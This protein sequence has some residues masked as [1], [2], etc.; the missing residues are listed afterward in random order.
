MSDLIGILYTSQFEGAQYE[1]EI[2]LQGFHFQ[3]IKFK[4]TG[5]KIKISSDLLE[6]MCTSQFEGASKMKWF[7]LN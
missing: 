6:N 5:G 3:T 1:F 2:N 4:Q 7:W